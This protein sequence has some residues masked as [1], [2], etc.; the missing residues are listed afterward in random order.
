M[1]ERIL[2]VIRDHC[3]VEEGSR[4]ILAVSGG[5]DSVCLLNLLKQLPYQISVAHLNHQLRAEAEQE[6]EFVKKMSASLGLPFFIESINVKRMAKTKKIGIEEAA[7][8]A[9]YKFLFETAEKENSQA[10]LTAH[11]ADDQIE[12]VLMNLIRGAGLRGMAGMNYCQTTQFSQRIPLIRPLLDFWKDEL[13]NYC[14]AYHLNFFIDQSNLSDHY[15]RNKIRNHLL[16]ILKGY[17]PNIKNTILRTSKTLAVDFDFI[18]TS[19]E[20]EKE[21]LRLLKKDDLI[22]FSL[23]KYR[24]LPDSL[25]DYFLIEVLQRIRGDQAEISFDLID[26]TKCTLDESN[27][28][29]ARNLGKE[30]FL[31]V[32][33]DTVTFTKDPN[34]VWKD[35]WPVCLSERSLELSNCT[36]DLGQD[37]HLEMKLS[38]IDECRN[39]YK[40]NQDRFTAYLDRSVISDKLAIRN[41]S[42]GDS[43]QPLG[44]DG[45][46]VKLTDF[47]IDRKIPSRA[48]ITWPLIVANGEI[49]WIPGFQPSHSFS[50]R[51]TTREILVLQLQHKP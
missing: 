28:M 43:Y 36:I 47:W 38:N 21:K 25:K 9:R 18:R 13:L 48:R 49:A 37:W 42:H 4:L 35:G 20:Q 17:N 39:I 11:H 51:E 7:R 12:T 3:C 41:W 19:L 44:M 40:I 29:V 26:Q 23:N 33:G 2:Q 16:P 5:P 14:S 31:L 27:R 8:C 45:K 34:L 22:S 10:V 46:K 1:K 32:E 6:A 30:I 15:F 50:I 24:S